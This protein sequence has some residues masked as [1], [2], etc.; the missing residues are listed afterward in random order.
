MANLTLQMAFDSSY[1]DFKIDELNLL[2]KVSLLNVGNSY[3]TR[4]ISDDLFNKEIPINA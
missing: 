3:L 1:I 2:H 4:G